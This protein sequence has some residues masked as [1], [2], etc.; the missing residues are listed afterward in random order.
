MDGDRWQ[1]RGIGRLFLGVDMIAGQLDV[2]CFHDLIVRRPY[3]RFSQT[4][5]RIFLHT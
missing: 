3:T 2:E 1:E 4:S 5:S